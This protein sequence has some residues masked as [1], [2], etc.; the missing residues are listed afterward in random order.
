MREFVGSSIH[1][2]AEPHE[3]AF[4]A[5]SFVTWHPPIGNILQLLEVLALYLSFRGLSQSKCL[6]QKLTYRAP[7]AIDGQ[8]TRFNCCC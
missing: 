4:G 6:D 7:S 5:T 8:Y 1:N 3:G 2:A